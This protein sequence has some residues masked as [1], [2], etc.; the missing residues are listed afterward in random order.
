MFFQVYLFIFTVAIWEHNLMQTKWLQN[1][2]DNLNPSAKDEHPTTWND[3][4]LEFEQ[5]KGSGA[6]Y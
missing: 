2:N 5:S 4:F 6:I 1:P 3:E